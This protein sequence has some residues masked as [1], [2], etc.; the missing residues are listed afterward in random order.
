[1]PA[2]SRKKEQSFRKGMVEDTIKTFKPLVERQ[3]DE[4]V[5]PIYRSGFYRS[6]E[7]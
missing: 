6:S 5:K 4:E 7:H 3:Q 1:M 2:L